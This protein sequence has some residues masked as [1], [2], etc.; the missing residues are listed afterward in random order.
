MVTG[1][2]LSRQAQPGSTV[3]AGVASLLARSLAVALVSCGLALSVGAAASSAP[4]S[5][6][7]PSH[8]F[9][10]SYVVK[11]T[12]P[13]GSHSVRAWIPLP[14][15]NDFQ[16]ISQMRLEAPAGIK[17]HKDGSH[18]AYFTGDTSNVQ[19]PFEVR[20]TFH[21]VRWERRLDM[22]PIAEPQ[23]SLP[24]EVIP[25]LQPDRLAPTRS[26][27][28]GLAQRQIQ[29][30]ADPLQ[31]ARKIYDYVVSALPVDRPALASAHQEAPGM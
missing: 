25:F 22:M 29:G 15:T 19:S 12:L 6:D 2:S 14:S 17:I 24:K 20:V 8:S 9:V 28:A 26:A 30:I 27:I 10:F 21:V 1:L 13:P 16:T 18:Y 23:G 4:N 7:P 3:R 31:Q 11:V 5:P